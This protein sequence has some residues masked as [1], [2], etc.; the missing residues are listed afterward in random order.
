MSKNV[1][2]I[3]GA[4]AG[5]RKKRLA[6]AQEINCFLSSSL[7]NSVF[8]FLLVSHAR[9]SR[10][11]RAGMPPHLRTVFGPRS[12]VEGAFSLKP[13]FPRYLMSMHTWCWS[14]G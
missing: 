6:C 2:H 9:A 5:S 8:Q 14:D 7:S 3:S 12:T 4:G 11:F 13:L 1:C 10:F